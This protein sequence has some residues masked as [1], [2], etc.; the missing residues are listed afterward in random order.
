MPATTAHARGSRGS[1]FAQA[2]RTMTSIH[3]TPSMT[4]VST[5]DGWASAFRASGST[6]AETCSRQTFSSEGAN[7][8]PRGIATPQDLLHATV[9]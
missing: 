5:G 9:Q 6:I 1:R 3:S 4:A 8:S 2:S 7:S